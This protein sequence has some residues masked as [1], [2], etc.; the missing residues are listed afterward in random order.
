MKLRCSP[1]DADE[2]KEPLGE[3]RSGEG[4]WSTHLRAPRQG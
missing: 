1:G 2:E 3:A 4:A